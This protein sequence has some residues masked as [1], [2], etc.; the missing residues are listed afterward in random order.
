MGRRWLTAVA[1]ALAV[2]LGCAPGAAAAGL[3]LGPPGLSETRST[4]AVAPGVTYTAIVRGAPSDADGFAVDVGFTLDR[5]AAE[6]TAADLRARGESASV[7]AADIH[8]PD[9]SLPGPTAYFARVGPLASQAE[10]QAVAARLTSAG[11]AKVR[12]GFTGDDG[13]TTTGPWRLHVLDIDPRRFDGRVAPVLATDVVPGRETV[14]SIDARLH[15][16]A[17]INGGYFVIGDAD[18]TPGDLAGISMIGGDLVSEA[19]DGRTDLLLPRVDGGGARIAAL[20]TDLSARASDGGRRLVDGINR[21][22]GLIRS[23]GG[24]GGDLP[25]E[26]P[27][28]DVTCTDPSELIRFTTRFGPETAPGSEVEAVLDHRGRVLAQRGGPGPIPAGGSVLAGTGDAAEWLRAHAR[29]GAR[30][31]VTEEITTAGGR[32]LRDTGHAL[33]VV[34]GGPRLLANGT[35]A[36]DATAEGFVHPDDPQFFY[37]FGVRRNPRTLAGVT[38]DGHLLLVAADGRAP[39]I[40]VGLSFA[41]EAA[42]MRALGA[43]DAVNLDGGGSTTL[44]LGSRLVTRPSDATGERPVGDAIVLLGGR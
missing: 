35:P 41:E 28:H 20:E 9:S 15:A 37:A 19:V 7:V 17:G 32:R 18:G 34:N 39:G 40:S 1:T 13:T 38:R 8:A 30:V 10:A 11:F 27:L 26:Q 42:V 44:A 5:A 43:T 33:G 21:R 12:T 24:D 16:L 2:A 29:A 14:T 6:Q 36:I 31:R 22:A 4:S 3:P 25:T 23:C